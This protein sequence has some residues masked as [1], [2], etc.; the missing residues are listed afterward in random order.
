MEEELI[1]YNLEL[2]RRFLSLLLNNANKGKRCTVRIN[3]DFEFFP[4]R[5]NPDVGTE[6][7]RE[8]SKLLVQW[9]LYCCITFL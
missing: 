9:E 1:Q 5:A 7:Y 3:F 8:F 4:W 2:F 6:M